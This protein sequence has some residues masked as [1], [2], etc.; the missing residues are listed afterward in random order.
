MYGLHDYT[1]PFHCALDPGAGPAERLGARM[2]PSTSDF[3]ALGQSVC[4]MR[5]CRNMDVIRIAA[6][7]PAMR[8]RDGHSE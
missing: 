1:S 7:I 8:D 2:A 5:L 3:G 4:R 6:V